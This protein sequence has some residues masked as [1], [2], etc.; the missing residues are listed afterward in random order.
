V[1]KKNYDEKCDLWSCGV[2]LYILLC[3]YPPFNGNTD[4]E[5]IS[6]VLLGKFA[7]DEPEWAEVSA[8]AKDLVSKLL[9]YDSNK[10]ISALNALCHPW[11][12]RVAT[13]EKINKE[14]AIKTLKNL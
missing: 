13:V 7:I 2:I 3:G 4:K 14:V 1:L 5:I 6:S 8:D 9:T 11:I 10:R 12:K